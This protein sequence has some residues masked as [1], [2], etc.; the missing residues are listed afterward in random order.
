MRTASVT[1]RGRAAPSTP[2]RLSTRSYWAALKRA[3]A[4]FQHDNL[5]D[6]ATALT[7]YGLLS[8]FPAVIVLVALVGLFGQY[9]RRSTRSRGSSPTQA[10]RRRP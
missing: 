3:I 2:V 4:E 1:P 10:S 7:H 9:R 8:L 6:G 5:M